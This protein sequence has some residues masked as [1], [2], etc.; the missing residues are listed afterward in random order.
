MD[1]C[2]PAADSLPFDQRRNGTAKK[3][4]FNKILTLPTNGQLSAAQNRQSLL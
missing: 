3:P 2:L 4:S 1:R